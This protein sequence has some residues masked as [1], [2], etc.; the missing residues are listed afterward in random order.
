MSIDTGH[1]V[2]KKLKR[3]GQMIRRVFV[4]SVITKGLR[5]VRTQISA[6]LSLNEQFSTALRRLQG[7]LLTAF[8]P[9]YEV[10]V[11][12]L[13]TL[14]QVLSQAIAVVTQFFASLFGT[15][16][17]KAQ[18]NAKAL[19]GQSKA[20]KETGKAAEEAAGSL[21]AF[22]EI[23]TIETEKDSGGGGGAADTGPL[24]DWEYD[25]DSFGS[26]GEAFSAFLDKLLAG[27]PKLEAAFKKFADWLNDLAKKLYDMFTFPGVLDKV[28]ALGKGLAEALNKLVNWIDWEMLG[29]A[30]GAGLNLALNFLTEFL[31]A[32]DWMNLG[33]KLADFVNGLVSEIDWYEFGRLLWAGFKIA[34]ETLAGFL[35][36]L[37]MPLMAKAAS[38]TIKGFFDEMYNTIERIPWGDIGKQ[39]AAFL[40]NIDWYGSITVALKAISAA[41]EALFELLDG[42]VRNLQW[43]DI[44]K[45]IYTAINDSLGLIDWRNIGQTLGNAFVQAFEFARQIIAGI[46]WHQIGSNIADFIL[47][48]D[49]VS[50]L[51]SLGQ[52]IAAGIN[53]AIRLACGF[54]DKVSPE[55]RA[56]A[57]G[58]AEGLRQAVTAVDWHAL[59]DVIGRGIKGAL[60]FVSGLLD[61]DLFYTIGRSIGNFLVS[62]DWVGIIGGLTEVLARAI[63]A[64]VKAV[65]GFL[66]SVQPDL[67]EIADGI[68]QKINEFVATVDWAELGQTIHDGIKAALD[69]LRTIL[70]NLDWDSIGSAIVDF[71]EN[72]DWPSLLAEWQGIVGKA[73]GGALQGVD[74]TDAIG[75][76]ANLVGGLIKGWLN[77]WNESG[78]IGGWLKRKFLS[79]FLSSFQSFFGIASPSKV[80]AEQGEYLVEGLKNGIKETWDGI[81]EFF[82]T[83]VDAIKD[84]FTGAWEDVKSKTSDAWNAIK[85]TV[86]GIWDGIKEK[87]GT[88][89]D[90]I[91]EKISTIWDNIK[92]KTSTIWENIKTTLS[93]AWDNL[94]TAAKEKF[95]NI[96]TVISTAWENIKTAAST[97]WDS[98]KSTLFTIWENLKTT[99]RTAFE[100]IKNTIS[101][102]WENIK[103]AASTTWNSIKSTLTGIW[104]SIKSEASSKF[105]QIKS[106]ISNAWENVKSSTSS[107]WA[108]IKS[109]VGSALSEIAG[110]VSSTFSD[111]VS[112]AKSWGSDIASNISSG[113]EKAGSKVKSAVNGVANR[114]RSNL[115]FSEPDEGPLKDFHTYMPDMLE[116]MAKGIRDNTH[117]AVSAASDLADSIAN[118]VSGKSIGVDMT[119]PD[120][121]KFSIPLA[122][123]GAKIPS[124]RE[125]T[126]ALQSESGSGDSLAQM[127]KLMGSMLERMGNMEIVIHNEL[128]VDG[129]K[130]AR[131]TVRHI[132]DMTRSA[133]RPVIDF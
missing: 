67:K 7:V 65:T 96:K 105:E 50:A 25:D 52:L 111:I 56:M 76:G 77:K 120:I 81:L 93:T 73:I 132:N 97:A 3:L 18:A 85:E 60:T 80:M 8:Q 109:T 53:A 94:K 23:N 11:P 102:A 5:A 128:A 38:D 41:F 9:I 4:F 62:L 123:Q 57:E 117:L 68:A 83:G 88:V 113:M 82:K 22:D 1:A 124:S 72:L 91:K 27:L 36:G 15:T 47:G 90:G 74:L 40:N 87:A 28:K 86:S 16:A 29:K 69:F 39:L 125:F 107:V 101:T 59:G 6:Y 55:L 118:T 10:V 33:R 54:L 64:A 121:S 13:T 2:G 98:I 100:G 110:K 71:L 104:D 126:M 112:R 51:S 84:F 78:G 103:S 99:S 37:D 12:A 114:I 61:P 19:Y 133:G 58:I 89:F 44:A 95:E 75:L 43:G 14:I 45:Q 116:L 21:A 66:D 49:F 35:L 31:Y 32:F 17:K 70:D 106:G 115:H 92:E 129:R 48:F 20:L 63:G 26:W 24:F 127:E 42:F 34:L 79:P 46:D 130:M 108:N 119:M 122:A 131:N 30:L